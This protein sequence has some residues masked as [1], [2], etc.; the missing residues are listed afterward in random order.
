MSEAGQIRLAVELPKPLGLKRLAMVFG[1]VFGERGSSA[2]PSKAQRWDDRGRGRENGDRHRYRLW[3]HTRWH[4]NNWHS[5]TCN[6]GAESRRSE[7]LRLIT[8]DLTKTSLFSAEPISRAI[9]FRL[10]LIRE[11]RSGRILVGR[12][13]GETRDRS[14]VWHNFD[15]FRP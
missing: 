14:K 11:T 2:A 13:L 7:Q 5:E 6:N 15:E 8:I 1:R 10:R 12:S 4:K 3:P 9:T